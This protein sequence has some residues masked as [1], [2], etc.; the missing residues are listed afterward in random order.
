MALIITCQI[1][2]RLLTN[3]LDIIS[4]WKCMT[5][6]QGIDSRILTTTT[7]NPLDIKYM[8]ILL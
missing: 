7:T 5:T 4:I 3:L 8:F 6:G 2:S 1:N